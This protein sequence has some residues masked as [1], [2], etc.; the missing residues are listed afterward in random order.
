MS[1]SSVLA[2]C[3]PGGLAQMARPVSARCLIDRTGSIKESGLV[4]PIS[5]AMQQFEARCA[6][7]PGAEVSRSVF[8]TEHVE[9]D[10]G[11]EKFVAG[12]GILRAPFA[13]YYTGFFAEHEGSPTWLERYLNHE[14][15]RLLN[16]FEADKAG[17]RFHLLVVMTDG[18]NNGPERASSIHHYMSLVRQHAEACGGVAKSR[19]V[20]WYFG[21]GLTREAHVEAATR[22]YNIPA[23]WVFHV[24]AT[25]E[26]VRAM[27]MR[28][29]ESVTQ[30]Y[31][32]GH[33]VIDGM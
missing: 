20:V 2:S 4:V 32:G 14:V 30:V 21:A 3:V 15:Q 11:C 5:M 24:P 26:G 9:L 33:T 31:R 17:E 1:G 12:S 28:M 29:T 6:E 22:K 10:G 7:L 25:A 18:K 16:R 8:D 13:A 27:G 23:E 19:I